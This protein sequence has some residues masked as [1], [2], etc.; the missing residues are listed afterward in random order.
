MSNVK[1]LLVAICVVAVCAFAGAGAQEDGS[2]QGSIRTSADGSELEMK[3]MVADTSL[4]E[5]VRL[6]SEDSGRAVMYDPR[7]V[8]GSIS[9]VAPARGTTV[10]PRDLLQSALAEFRLVLVSDGVFD[11]II[12]AAEA[13]TMCDSVTVE[14]LENRSPVEYVRVLIV[15]KTADANA[16]RGA[17]QNLTTRQGGVVNPIPGR[18]ALIIADTVKNVRSI[19]ELIK[20][21]ENEGD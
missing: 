21:F 4:S 9:V 6:Y 19:V 8:T 5:L 18:N 7:R 14:E 1:R 2:D 10:A 13:V 17:V 12:P 15:L 3:G 20:V 16:V 11:K